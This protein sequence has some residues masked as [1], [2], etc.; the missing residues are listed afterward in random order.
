[1]DA[2]VSQKQLTPAKAKTIQRWRQSVDELVAFTTEHGRF[3][4]ETGLT[5]QERRLA[6]LRRQAKKKPGH[7]ARAIFDEL[8][9]GWDVDTPRSSIGCGTD[10][11][12]CAPRTDALL[13][14]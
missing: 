10:R 6:R 5:D 11:V 7:G 9:P 1:M 4:S 3:P 13:G 2:A 8:M 12:L 14:G